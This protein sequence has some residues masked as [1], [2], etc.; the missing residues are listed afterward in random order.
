[1]FN[2]NEHDNSENALEIKYTQHRHLLRIFPKLERI[3]LE[4][5]D[6]LI[7]FNVKL[8]RNNY[9]RKYIKSLKNSKTF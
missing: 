9:L 4:N 5:V 2:L 3:N 1:M 8:S 6:H 7:D